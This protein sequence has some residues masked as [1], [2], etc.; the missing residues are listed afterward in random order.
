MASALLDALGHAVAESG[1][2][3]VATR[4][5]DAL[6]CRLR[7]GELPALADR[8]AELGAS[9]QFLAAAA[10]R[11]SSGDFTLVSASAPAT[12]SPR[13][14]VLVSVAPDDA[15]FPSL[16]TRSFAASRFERE[17][18]DLFGLTPLDHPDLRRLALHQFWPAGYHPLRR[19]TAARDEF[20]NEGGTL[21][22]RR[23]EGGRHFLLI[24]GPGAAGMYDVR[25]LPLCLQCSTILDI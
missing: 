25:R 4:A 2:T 3:G 5:P 10:R 20:R 18:H 22:V 8:L 7:A 23:G 12:L 11:A 9:C 16:A 6:E 24:V 1:A 19:D 15:R 14:V 21:P 13:A 17:I